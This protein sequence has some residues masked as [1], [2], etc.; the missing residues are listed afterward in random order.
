[1]LRLTHRADRAS[2]AVFKLT[3]NLYV[4]Y[5]WQQLFDRAEP[6]SYGGMAWPKA[7][8][9]I[10]KLF[11]GASLSEGEPTT[12]AG[13]FAVS[14]RMLTDDIWPKNDQVSDDIKR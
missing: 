4:F 9:D 12:L 7:L 14:K 1:M 10:T 13:M 2:I 6:P 5:G 11:F 8:P 3:Y